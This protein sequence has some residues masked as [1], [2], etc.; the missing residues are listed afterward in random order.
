MD[1]IQTDNLPEMIKSH[2]NSSM[3]KLWKTQEESA[4]NKLRRKFGK[5][6][7]L[8]AF[9]YLKTNGIPPFGEVTTEPLNFLATNEMLISAFNI[10]YRPPTKVEEFSSEIG[11]QDLI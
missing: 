10:G 6:K 1:F 8:N 7:V 4:F 5:D 9:S 11:P 3:S 2:L